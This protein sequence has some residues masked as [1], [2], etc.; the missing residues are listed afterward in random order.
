MTCQPLLCQT[1]PTAV[2]NVVRMQT[3]NTFWEIIRCFFQH[4]V[5]MK[6]SRFD[7]KTQNKLTMLCRNTPSL[8]SNPFRKPVGCHE[9]NN[10]LRQ[11]ALDNNDLGTHKSIH[12]NA[13]VS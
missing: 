2:N 8:Y 10:S 5:L 13:M 1:K 11:P 7:R 3:I 4:V 9:V 12:G 6:G